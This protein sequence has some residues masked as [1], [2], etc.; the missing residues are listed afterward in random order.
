[1]AVVDAEY[2]FFYV[3]MLVATVVYRMVKYSETV[4]FNV[5]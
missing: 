2:N 3:M 1:M 4:P 5:L